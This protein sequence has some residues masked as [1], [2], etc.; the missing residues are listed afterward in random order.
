MLK[1]NELS[2]HEK[3]LKGNLS[4]YY[5]VKEANAWRV[6]YCVPPT[7]LHSGRGKTTETIK[8]SVAATAPRAGGVRGPQSFWA[9]RLF[10]MILKG[11]QIHVI[12]HLSELIQ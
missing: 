2:S 4:A 11:W 5:K 1:G 7:I 3:D 12:E 10:P 9:V 6:I 8:G